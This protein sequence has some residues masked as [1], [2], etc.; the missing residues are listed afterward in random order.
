MSDLNIL[1]TGKEYAPHLEYWSEKV[2]LLS[3]PFQLRI[4][5]GDPL[6]AGKAM[7]EAEFA[8]EQSQ[9]EIISKIT[10]DRAPE[11]FVILVSSWSV[12]LSKYGHND[13]IVIDSPLFKKGESAWVSESRVP[14]IEE[15]HSDDTIRELIIRTDKTISQS[16]K[17]QSFPTDIVLR[18]RNA[19]ADLLRTNLFIRF[20]E[21]HA[22]YET[23]DGYDIIL[24]IHRSEGTIRLRV[25]CNPA[26]F[27]Q[28]FMGNLEEHYKNVIRSFKDTETRIR[29]I[30]VLSE[31]ERHEVLTRFNDTETLYPK[32]KSLV[33][34]FEEQAEKNPNAVALVFKDQKLTYTE[35]NLRAN[36]LAHYLRKKGAG[37]DSVVAIMENR[38]PGMIITILGVLKAGAAYLPIDKSPADRIT[39]MLEHS[40]TDILVCREA[41][42]P[43]IRFSGQVIFAD[44]E[45]ISV[46]ET[47]NPKRINR[48]TD[49]AYVIYTSGSTG[50]P[51]GVLAEHRSVVRLVKNTNYTNV[52]PEDRILQLSNYAFDGSTYD[53]YAALLNGAS[54]YLIPEKLVYSVEDL[55]AYITEN[56]INITFI[57]TAL[58]NKLIDTDP[59]VI[60]NFDKIFFGGQDASLKHVRKS[61]Q[62][63]KNEDSIVHVYGP[64]ENT[65][66]ST[67]YVVKKIS[68]DQT[69]VPIG[70]GISN[71]RVYVL[72]EYLNP[73]PIGIE[74][75]LCVSGD[76]IARGYLNN[77]ILT[78]EKFP[79]N[80]FVPG[81]RLYRTGDIAKWLPD[82]NIE[83]LGRRDNQVKIRGFRIELGEVENNLLKHPLIRQC[84]VMPRDSRGGN[85][86]LIAYIVGAEGVSVSELREHLLRSLPDYMVPARF[87]QVPGLPLS[88]TT[89]KVDK[90]LLPDPD[91][92]ELD[93]GTEYEAPRNETEQRLADIW[94]ELMGKQRVGIRDNYFSLGGDSIKAIQVTS[95]L[96]QEG[97][98]LDIRNIFLYP[99]IAE[100]A[101]NVVIAE[102]DIDQDPVTG[103]VPLTPVQ[104]WFFEHFEPAHRHHFN[105]AVMFYSE[106]GFQEDALS[107]VFGKIQEHH[108]AMRMRYR[109]EGDEIIQENCGTDYP[110]N[111]EIKDLRDSEHVPA[112]K[113]GSPVSELESYAAKTHAGIRPDTGPL[114][115]VVLFRM[116]DGDRLLIVI[117]HLI[118]DG[119]S[120][121]I[122]SEDM[123]R[124]YEH[125]VAG[126]PIRFPSKTHSFKYWAERLRK[127]GKQEELLKEV[128]YW[129][130]LESVR[131][132]PL[133]RDNPGENACF[134][135][136]E[137]QEFSLSR[138]H[139]GELLT[140]VNHAYHTEI[141]DILL[142]ALARAMKVWH[143]ENRTLITLEGHG[144]EALEGV[145]ISR[146][147]G[148]FTS[149]FPVILELPDSDDHGYQ[150][151]HIK[152]SLRK[153][154]GK[155]M[156]YGIL[157]YLTPEDLREGLSFNLQPQISFNY[158]GQFDEDTG[159][160]FRLAEESP[161]NPVSPESVIIH[162]LEISG[163]V[164]RGELQISVCYNGVC[165]KPETIGM[166]AASFK[167]EL[168]EI[169]NHCLNIKDSEI[170]PSDIDYEGLDID[171]LDAVLDG[172]TEG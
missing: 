63:R 48:P 119:V 156:G 100:L 150:I 94:Q 162:D 158:L 120:W 165:Y 39:A 96:G 122:L 40:K 141:N 136:T 32:D 73:L 146:T 110:L 85:K 30:S 143:G 13:K 172:L 10:Q 128:A 43:D 97:F 139:T 121:R 6:N 26:M 61:L 66:F 55:C 161:G 84:F 130:E 148:W 21:I 166:F 34:L 19:D 117:H 25:A 45:D 36:Q 81:D 147:V 144:R 28:A 98:R 70:A 134:K 77:D 24:N 65:T 54:L 133:P 170:T 86:E 160:L 71:T 111:F 109:T 115:K 64:T 145:D 17:Y 137:T 159:G 104:S 8:L 52:R 68:E 79:A 53:I 29:D 151:K 5:R 152:E 131:V 108:D 23:A 1:F 127:Y 92:S 157:K 58:F 135:D 124:G 37:P 93:L 113:Q 99:T 11:V 60:G 4:G 78:A 129:K 125:Y 69:S 140:R 35:L 89:G 46:E 14:L 9:Q 153:I 76:G 20:N 41:T 22:S 149:I 118:I 171:E 83:F 155:G 105:Q 80:P 18:Q 154:P 112:S 15:I 56:K 3:E 51:K 107:P 126:K 12:L 44:H 75:E 42:H 27:D 164:I 7:T 106:E 2:S 90:K 114:M 31:P 47:G 59:Q 101:P 102:I 50:E 72:D 57:T 168:L 67:Y 82:G 142:T 33:E 132:S 49:L 88:S 169:I 167:Q 138:E 74:G 123:V 91:D 87:V 116:N 163:M 103:Q 62:Y 38:G 95:R 16:Y